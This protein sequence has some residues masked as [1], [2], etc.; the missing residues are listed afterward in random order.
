M[1][2]INNDQRAV[3]T[4][5]QKRILTA[6]DVAFSY[7][8]PIK[9]VW[10]HCRTGVIPHARIGRIIRFD[11]ELLDDW[12][13]NGGTTRTGDANESANTSVHR[14]EQATK[15]QTRN[16]ATS[17]TNEMHYSER[18]VCELLGVSQPTLSRWRRDGTSPP[19]E[20][21]GPRR[22]VYPCDGFLR[23]VMAL[24]SASSKKN[25][26]KNIAESKMLPPNR[27]SSDE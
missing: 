20:R 14:G 8:I 4:E 10:R 6:E 18:E 2:D 25:A 9:S 22:I 12:F 17:A 24:D 11:K 27:D 16:K 1:S 13:A 3:A 5:S 15:T 23:W 19:F 7:G 21:R 26:V